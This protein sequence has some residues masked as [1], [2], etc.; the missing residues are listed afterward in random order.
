MP[1]DHK[2][3]NNGDLTPAEQQAA[4]FSRQFAMA[5]ELPFVIVSAIAVGELIGFFL[6]R[7]LLHRRAAQ[8]SALPQEIHTKPHMM[9]APD[10]LGFFGGLREVLRRLKNQ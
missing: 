5:M 6:D 1:S 7:W 4:S 9:L 2:E 3:Q 8:F 10:F